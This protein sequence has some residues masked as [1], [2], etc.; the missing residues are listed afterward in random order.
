MAVASLGSCDYTELEPSDMVGPDKAFSTEENLRRA[1]V[2]VYSQMQLEEKFKITEWIVDDSRLGEDAGGAGGEFV[3][4]TFSATSGDAGTCWNHNYGII[5]MTNQI[6]TKCTAPDSESVRRSLGEAYFFRAFAHFELLS[7]FSDFSKDENPGIPYLDHPHV[8]EKPARTSVKQ[9]FE[10][11]MRDLEEAYKLIPNVKPDLKAGNFD[12]TSNSYLSKAAVDAL[13]ARV[14]LYHKDYANADKY[15]QD[16]LNAIGGIAKMEEVAPVWLDQSNAG[17]FFKFARP[18]GTSNLGH[19]FVG[20]DWSSIFYPSDAVM[21]SYTDNDIRKAD[22]IFFRMGHKR[23]GDP[24]M[25]VTKWFGT[26]ANIGHVDQKVIRAEEML[27]IRVEALMESDLATAGQLLNDLRAQRIKDY[28][29]MTFTSANIK[30][31][32]I[33]E[34]RRELAWEGH[35]FIDARRLNFKLKAGEMSEERDPATNHRFIM[36]IPKDEILAN[37][38]LQQN[39]GY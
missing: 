20:P 36:P 28:K 23:D 14:S 3:N 16:A 34:R 19:I 31:E 35:R 37:P 39:P 32:L 13:R 8:L 6:L 27:L 26:E 11:I 15:A 30:D 24:V 18:A 38:N 21:A 22:G 12:L 33:L 29:P 4:W 25:M 9:C 5:D 7:L 1:I 17:V 2:G 10:Y